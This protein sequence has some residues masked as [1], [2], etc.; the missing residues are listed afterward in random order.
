MVVESISLGLLLQTLAAPDFSGSVCAV[1]ESAVPFSV[2]VHS[3]DGAVTASI[4][5]ELDLAT[6]P[7]VKDNL[8]PFL[9]RSARVVYELEQ[10]A[11]IDSA[12]LESL[13][14]A[15]ED[16]ETIIFLNPSFPVRRLVNILDLTVNVEES[17]PTDS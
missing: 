17:V 13:F 9:G 11:F 16:S 3:N 6:G 2:S 8:R 10:V 7:T 4:A 5:G 14:E 12:G 15:T 1:S